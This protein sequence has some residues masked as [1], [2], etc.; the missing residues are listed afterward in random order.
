[1]SWHPTSVQI[2]AWVREAEVKRENHRKGHAR[3]KRR[4]CGAWYST[5][6]QADEDG[7][8]HENHE[9]EYVSLTLARLCGG[10]E[11]RMRVQSRAG[12]PQRKVA[13]AIEHG[14]NRLIRDVKLRRKLI[15]V[16]EDMLFGWGVMQVANED[17]VGRKAIK[18]VQPKRPVPKRISPDRCGW[19]PHATDWEDKRFAFH[20]WVMTRQELL[21]LADDEESGWDKQAI[22]DL[23]AGVDKKALGRAETD[24]DLDGIEEIDGWEVWVRDEQLDDE[25][26]PE[27]G[28]NGVIHT[29]ASCVTSENKLEGREI[30]EPRAYYG[31]P[32]G[33]YVFFGY[34]PVPDESFPLSPLVAV[35]SQ[36]DSLNAFTGSAIR[37]AANRKR[38]GIL[39]ASEPELV[40][41]KDA[42]DGEWVAQVAFDRS[43]AQEYEIG[44]LTPQMITAV[45]MER[46][47]LDRNSG[48]FEAQRGSVT[49]AATASE[50]V[51]ANEASSARFALLQQQADAGVLDLCNVL[52]WYLYHDERVIF[53]LGDETAE[54]I[55][56][57]V[58]EAPGP[59]SALWFKGGTFNEPSDYTYE[60]LELDMEPYS[61]GR[62][63][64]VVQAQRMG[65]L[66]NVA[67]VIAP[68]LVQNPHLDAEL[69]MSSL[70]DSTNNDD[71]RKLIDYRAL[72]EMRTLFLQSQVE[73]A[74]G[75]AEGTKPKLSSDIG[76]KVQPKPSGRQFGKP[77]GGNGAMKPAQPV[78]G[79]A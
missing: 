52:A 2:T 34:L 54:A 16:F 35:K 61:L 41:I 49:G 14:I 47:R 31:P 51:I 36:A 8:Q 19:D 59:E 65:Q 43:K 73:P 5:T 28:Y 10:G 18:G 11:P 72:A 45:Q 78:K 17:A 1:M 30:R 33:P 26:A 24:V 27:K 20:R 66:V 7:L 64:E 74:Q 75:E 29:L 44:G 67:T 63:S 4:F 15:P 12:A 76:P 60:D 77:A 9:Y 46:E 56:E 39:E 53:P 21:D 48:I 57:E 6:Q 3:L 23:P 40:K 62:T 32:S 79:A 37:A 25:H 70:A 55:E 71:L 42:K 13:Q 38:I 68:A 22:R 50:N 58:G 69:L